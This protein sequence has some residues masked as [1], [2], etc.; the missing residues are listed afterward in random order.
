MA[1]AE[2]HGATV[3]LAVLDEAWR[4]HDSSREQALLPAMIT[5]KDSQ[6]WQVSTAGTF[7]STYFRAQVERGRD[8]VA[9][10]RSAE[11]RAAFFEW[12]MAEGA[13]WQDESLWPD[14]V[15]ALGT[16]IDMEGLRYRRA[17]MSEDDF[18][19]AHLN[20]WLTFL[21]EGAVPIG[22]WEACRAAPGQAVTGK[23]WLGVDVPPR[24]QGGGGLVVAGN[25][26]LG[27][28]DK[29]IGQGWTIGAIR[30]FAL[31]WKDRLG[32]VAVIRSGAVQGIGEILEA[33]GIDVHWY[34]WSKLA[35][36]CESFYEALT[37][38]DVSIVA[39]T[40]LDATIR[41]AEARD[42]IT[43]SWVWQSRK[44]GSSVS[45]LFA[46]TMAFDLDRRFRQTPTS[47]VWISDWSQDDG[48]DEWLESYL[49]E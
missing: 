42:R 32:G 22:D 43:G 24:G 47:E 38:R 41:R 11:D 35:I 45:L 44:Q 34:D 30:Q 27:V 12:G 15:P 36:A 4:M 13:D 37:M 9:E 21:T 48:Y 16:T 14:A 5:V 8:R 28:V 19:R 33:E 49:E 25:N 1:E 40:A 2:G 23:L 7:E 31:R 6:M 29:G 26:V 46:A 3:A 17:T 39:D 18:R 10:G 20:Q